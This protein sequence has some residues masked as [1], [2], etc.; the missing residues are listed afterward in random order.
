[1]ESLTYFETTGWRGVM[2]GSLGSPAPGKFP[3]TPGMH[4]PLYHLFAALAPCAGGQVLPVTVSDPLQIACLSV[5]HEGEQCTI[6]GNLRDTQ[7][8]V[9]VQ[10][11]TGVTQLKTLGDD[12]GEI[13]F[14]QDEV[15]LWVDLAPY[16]LVLLQRHTE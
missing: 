7:Q 1:V 4:F 16:A 12:A 8:R 14:N 11:L 9:A 13:E 3:S 5:I 10:G 6:I 2:E 15:P